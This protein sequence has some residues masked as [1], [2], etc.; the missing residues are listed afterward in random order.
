MQD[1]KCI[2]RAMLSTALQTYVLVLERQRERGGGFRREVTLSWI[3]PLLEVASHIVSCIDEELQG[4]LE[5][6]PFDYYTAINEASYH[7]TA[8]LMSGFFHVGQFCFPSLIR[9]SS[10]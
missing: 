4:G 5:I 10:L 9:S 6:N 3:R 1:G 7:M 8:F 2:G